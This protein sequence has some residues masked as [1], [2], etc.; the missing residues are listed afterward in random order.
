MKYK[1]SLT[2]EKEITETPL[3][4]LG[5]K[6]PISLIK[7]TYTQKIKNEREL[8]LIEAQ[9]E[10]SV[11]LTNEI[12]EKEKN[13][14]VFIRKETTIENKN[15]TLILKARCYFLEDIGEE[16]EVLFE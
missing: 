16:A 1:N 11:K 14:S 4:L 6:M 10:L 9:N 12:K 2:S 7:E 8:T 5:V 15:N 13:D 3:Y